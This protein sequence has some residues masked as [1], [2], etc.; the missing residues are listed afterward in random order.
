MPSVPGRVHTYDT[1]AHPPVEKSLASDL[2]GPREFLFC[3]NIGSVLRTS[4][5]ADRSVNYDLRIR[6]SDA[7]VVV[8]DDD[9]DAVG[10]KNFHSSGWEII[11]QAAFDRRRRPL[12]KS[13]GKAAALAIVFAFESRWN[14]YSKINSIL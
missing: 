13:S 12:V 4:S 14:P 10:L 9:G 1:A 5:T 8:D 11:F 7:V 6:F 3:S 2:K